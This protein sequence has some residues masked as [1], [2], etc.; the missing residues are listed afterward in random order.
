MHSIG[1]FAV[2]ALILLREKLA[3]PSEGETKAHQN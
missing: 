3:L 2:V 1:G